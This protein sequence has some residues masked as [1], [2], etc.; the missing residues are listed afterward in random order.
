MALK[1]TVYKAELSIADLDR[2]YY[3]DHALTLARH[4]SETDERMMVRLIAFA[5]NASERLEFGRGLGNEEEPALWRKSLSGEVELWID[6]GHPEERRLRKASGVATDVKCTA[7]QSA[8]RSSGGAT[9]KPALRD[10]RICRLPVCKRRESI[11]SSNVQ[12]ASNARSKAATF[13]SRAT[14]LSAKSASCRG[15]PRH[16][17][18]RHQ[19][20]IIELNIVGSGGTS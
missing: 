8:A 10:C 3:Q 20:N 12:C 6:V 2:N 19:L 15:R 1:A 17:V 9:M 5:L 13:G 16:R 18:E 11:D 14:K 7:T 4:P